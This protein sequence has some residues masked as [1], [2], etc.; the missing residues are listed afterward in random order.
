MSLTGNGRLA[1]LQQKIADLQR[2]L[3]EARRR[4]DERTA[5]RDEALAQQLATAEVLGVINSSP[6]DLAP[7]FDAMLERAMRLCEASFGSFAIIDQGLLRPVA[8]R[9]VPPELV[10]A[11]QPIPWPPRMKGGHL[12]QIANG[13]DVVPIADFSDTA[14]YRAGLTWA[15]ALVDQGGARTAVWVALRKDQALLGL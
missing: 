11:L 14:A 9:D 12:E 4:L 5:E 15:V 3:S 10:E 6:G 8:H 1:D 13:E 2:R 7:V